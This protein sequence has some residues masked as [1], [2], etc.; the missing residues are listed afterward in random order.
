MIQQL[1]GAVVLRAAIFGDLGDGDREAGWVHHLTF[2]WANRVEF[3]SLS[4]RGGVDVIFDVDTGN[5][6]IMRYT[7]VRNRQLPQP[8]LWQAETYIPS[9]ALLG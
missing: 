1:Q 8:K 9:S 7:A 4:C 5:L 3:L 2:P 6:D